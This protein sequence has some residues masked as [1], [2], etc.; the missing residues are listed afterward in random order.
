MGRQYRIGSTVTLTCVLSILLLLEGCYSTPPSS[1][2]HFPIANGSHTLLPSERQRIFIWGDPLLTRVADEWLR[3]HQYLNTLIPP[4]LS[5]TSSD[6]QVALAAAT[7][8]NA[9][10][11]LILEREELKEGALTQ[12]NCGALFNI[13]VDVRGLSVERQEAVLRGNAHYPH[14]VEHNDQTF[15]NL[16]CQALATAWGFRPPGQLEIPSHL[17][18]TAGQATPNR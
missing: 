8:A 10:F 16:T 2:V 18:C 1:G 14:C 11:V 5:H 17:A 9:E 4:P 15:Q 6:H 7:E 12:P 3:S 13:N